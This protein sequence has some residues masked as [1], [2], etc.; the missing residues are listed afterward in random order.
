VAIKQGRTGELAVVRVRYEIE[1]A[2]VVAVVEEQEHIYRFKSATAGG[3]RRAVATQASETPR[4]APTWEHFA[5]PDPLLLFRFS[6]VTANS[7]RIHYDLSYARDEEGYPGLVVHGPLQAMWMAELLRTKTGKGADDFR[8]R[9][10]RPA[11]AGTT[12]HVAGAS[13]DTTDATLWVAD[14]DGVAHAEATARQG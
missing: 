13:S 9:L 12:L 3:S 7:H 14:G 2:G 10:M 5:E 11:F 8:Y 4:L 1:Q 6:A